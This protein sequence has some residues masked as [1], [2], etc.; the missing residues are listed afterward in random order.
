MEF[1]INTGKV[2]GS[3]FEIVEFS[4]AMKKVNVSNDVIKVTTKRGRPHLNSGVRTRIL[5]FLNNHKSDWFNCKAICGAVNLPD[6]TVSPAC[7]TLYKM[8]LVVR[9]QNM[10]KYEYCISTTKYPVS[11][12]YNKELM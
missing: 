5:D 12:Y 10:G 1:D 7:S 9:R 6:N 11:S 2:V 4:K 3:V 8:G